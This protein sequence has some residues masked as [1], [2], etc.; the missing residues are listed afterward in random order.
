MKITITYW[1]IVKSLKICEELRINEYCVKDW[2]VD[3][4]D[5]IEITITKENKWILDELK[6]LVN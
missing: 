4:D 3:A 1:T 6:D 2:I 5:T